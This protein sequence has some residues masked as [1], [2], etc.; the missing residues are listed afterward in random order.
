MELGLQT[1]HSRTARA[2]NLRYERADFENAAESLARHNIDI[3]AHIILGLPG[4]NRRDMLE[5]A[6]FVA[7]SQVQ[8]IKIHLLHVM[9]NTPLGVWYKKQPFEILELEEY[10]NLVA[11]I[12]EIIPP[13][14]IV[15]RLTGDSPR[16][17]LLAPQWSLKKREILNHI[18]R[19]MLERDT[20]QGKNYSKSE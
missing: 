12:L 13:D 19:I 7:Q 15:H 17:L 4:E 1:V 20:W 8:G 6:R 3:C 11:D 10:V 16:Q 9:N 2:M 5:T 14:M 18:D